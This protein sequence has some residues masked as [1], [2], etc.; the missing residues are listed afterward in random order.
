[1]PGGDR[2]TVE[3]R[4]SHALEPDPLDVHVRDRHLALH[5][6]SLGLREQRSELVDRRLP[7]PREIGRALSR[8]GGRIQIRGLAAHRL[9]SAQQ[10][11]LLRLV[12]DDVGCGQVAEQQRAGERALRRRRRRRPEVLADLD[13]EHEVR[14]VR[15]G[16]H[17]VGA[18]RDRLAGQCRFEADDAHAGRE[19]AML[20]ELAV[21]RQERLRDGAED[22]PARHD[23]RAVVESTVAANRCAEHEYRTQL[24]RYLDEV[25]KSRLDAVEQ[26]VLQQQVV[27]RIRGQ[28]ELR[29]QHE[30]HAARLA[31]VHHRQRLGRVGG[32]IADLDARRAGRDAD[33]AL[34]VQR[35]ELVGHRESPAAA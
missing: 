30:V 25:R 28:P 12:D 5:G 11:P 26:R 34:A 15:S 9:R 13:V 35:E 21:V 14:K 6:K 3:R 23:D 4:R 24:A 22:P 20:V 18:E 2:C 32:G 10:R 8:S 19:P 33:E 29:E 7:V 1:M 27:D 17:Q 31:V 16:E